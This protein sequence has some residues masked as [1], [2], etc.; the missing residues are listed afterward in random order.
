[1]TNPSEK[2]VIQAWQKSHELGLV[3]VTL[4]QGDRFHHELRLANNVDSS[5]IC[6]SIEGTDIDVWP[7]SPPMQD[8]TLEE[9]NDTKL[10]LGVGRAG[11]SHWGFSCEAKEGSGVFRFEIACHAKL[12]AAFLGSTYRVS[13][14]AKIEDK[15]TSSNSAANFVKISTA[16]GAV[17][18]RPMQH[19]KLSVQGDVL[20]ISPNA[21]PEKT[22][23]TCIWG[24]EIQIG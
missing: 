15:S 21:L 19:S 11:K 5:D 3:G 22:P 12:P 23:A 9:R 2:I 6:K 18:I 7:V 24:Y 14:G 17:I 20:T 8:V 4:Q 13:P 10:L 16:K 1:M